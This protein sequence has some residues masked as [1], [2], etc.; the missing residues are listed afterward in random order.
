[1]PGPRQRIKG[2][3][4]AAIV[5]AATLEFSERGF[6][7]AG[8]DRIARRARVNKAL[9][10]YYFG[11][12]LA[13]Y[14]EVVAVGIQALAERLAVVAHADARADAKIQR[15][16]EELS[17]FLADHPAVTPL[18]LRELAD[19]GRHFDAATLRRLVSI[20]PMVVGIV[21]QGRDEGT[22]GSTDPLSLHFVILGSTMLFNA[23]APIRR[24][25]N[26]LGIAQPPIDVTPFV[27]YL[28]QVALRMLRKDPH[29]G[30]SND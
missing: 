30:H 14:R 26:Q 21:K 29:H 22:F 25:V 5:N 8:V 13:L 1:M 28:Q 23:N 3:R 4:R 9:L 2:D 16:V 19:G 7:A 10:Y 12:K 11:S 6:A 24:R 27:R 15:W 18:M 17:A 20:L